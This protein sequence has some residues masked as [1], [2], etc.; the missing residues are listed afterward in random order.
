MSA[1]L[2]WNTWEQRTAERDRF[3]L[4]VYF[5]RPFGWPRLRQHEILA[6]RSS[7]ITINMSN[8]VSIFSAA[9]KTCYYFSP[10]LRTTCVSELRP[11]MKH[12]AV[13]LLVTKQTNY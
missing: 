8:A 1:H 10:Y 3:S 9:P 6:N 13:A 12:V 7:I 2:V 11:K 5:L 4:R